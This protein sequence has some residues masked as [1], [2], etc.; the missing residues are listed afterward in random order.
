M[1]ASALDGP[2]FGVAK[3]LSLDAFMRS[4]WPDDRFGQCASSIARLLLAHCATPIPR[5]RS[6]DPSAVARQHQRSGNAW[7][8]RVSE[9][10]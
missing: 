7:L 9:V 3:T 2:A 4:P 1:S 10:L 6:A 5:R 8:G